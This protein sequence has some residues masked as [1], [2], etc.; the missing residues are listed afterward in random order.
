MVPR[1][2]LSRALLAGLAG[3]LAWFASLFVVF[4]PAQGVL[5][6]PAVQSPKLLSAFSGSTPPR[7]ADA[8]WLAPVGLLLIGLGIGLAYH[9]IATAFTG[10]AWS[11]GRRFGLLLWLVAIPWFE[12]YLPWNVLREPTVLAALELACWFVTMQLVSHA[13]VWTYHGRGVRAATRSE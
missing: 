8:A 9:M 6:D 1:V 12:F 7:L 3:G 2:A 5:Q 10:S 4:G 13:V 11:R